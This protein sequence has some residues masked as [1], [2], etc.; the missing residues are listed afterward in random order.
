[1]AIRIRSEL[2][3]W[4]A[5]FVIVIVLRNNL[6]YQESAPDILLKKYT[7]LHQHRTVIKI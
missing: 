1:M 7:L 5:F 2:W 4:L 6:A 3:T